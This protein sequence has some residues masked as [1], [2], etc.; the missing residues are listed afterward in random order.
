[1]QLSSVA[2]GTVPHPLLLAAPGQKDTQA[3]GP[4]PAGGSASSPTPQAPQPPPPDHDP[5]ERVTIECCDTTHATHALTGVHLA[6]EG[7]QMANVVTGAFLGGT[8]G[9]SLVG[10]GMTSL[11][12]YQVVNGIRERSFLEVV[13]GTGTALLGVRSGLEAMATGG[14]ALGMHQ[15]AHFAHGAHGWLEPLGIA[16]GTIEAGL[17]AYTLYEGFSNSDKDT[18]ISGAMGIGLGASVVAASAGGGLTAV[19]AATAFL[20]GKTLYHQHEDIAH[21]L[22]FGP[23]DDAK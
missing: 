21:L 17:G 2:Q 3:T 13:E 18:M 10:V 16:H 7:A 12:T 8:L 1:M 11:G 6:I 9:N 20:A 15:V 14:D 23:R 4:A 22:S 5:E 19:L